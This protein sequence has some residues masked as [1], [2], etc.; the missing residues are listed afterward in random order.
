MALELRFLGQMEV[1]RNGEALSLPPSRKT[2][3][4][5]AYLALS[6]RPQR[7]EQ[8]VPMFWNVP[9]DPRGALRWSL[10]KLRALTDAPD[11]RRIVTTRD[12]VSFDTTAAKVDLLTVR[13]AVRPG[14]ETLRTDVLTVLEAA[15]RGALLEGLELPD[16]R[17]FQAWITAER[18]DVRRLHAHILRELVGRL[19]S[20]P[21]DGLAYARKLASVDPYAP[22]AHAVLYRLLLATGRRDE[23]ARQREQSTRILE[24]VGREALRAYRTALKEPEQ[25]APASPVSAPGA[26]ALDLPV[27]VSAARDIEQPK[28]EQEIRFCE[29]PDGVQLAYATIGE[30]PPIVK[31]PNWM[32]H[33][34]YE[35]ESPV[36]RHWLIEL[37]R[38]NM[39]V[40]YDER[41][42]GLSDWNVEEIS[43]DASLRDL[44]TVVDTIGLDRFT[45]F[46]ISQGCA[47]SVAYA[48]RHPERVEKLVL[49][50]GYARGWKKRSTREQMERNDALLSLMK[51]GWGQENPAFRQLFTTLFMPDASHEQMA[52][53]NNLQRM[54]T[55][56]ENAV[57]I[58]SARG[59]TDIAPLLPQVKAPTLVFHCLSDA[60]VPFAEGR[61]L[62]M[63]IPNA[64]FVPL[65][66]RNHLILENEPAWPR[67][68]Y[69][70]RR[71]L[72]PSPAR[73]D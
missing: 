11:C 62:A 15:F 38:Q 55:S 37:S 24:D 4:L 1:A 54:T 22:D 57:R 10:S 56:P 69:E 16:C 52:W 23:A 39:L 33:L 3:A 64:R 44:E 20:E 70:L 71:V 36:W 9:D 29:A 30:G 63:K 34:E 5:L 61:Y 73:M 32:S 19:R 45:L 58:R 7:R 41:G 48:V 28:A 43:F 6:G 35:W 40:R 60:M 68:V 59:D 49:Y 47:I 8:L 13:N 65:D 50:G 25:I 42:N 27:N 2:R 51:H 46:G 17:D 26:Q 12:S 14:V 18:E 21:E 66:S 31:A 67:F 72:A 53:F